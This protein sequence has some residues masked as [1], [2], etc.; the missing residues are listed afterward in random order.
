MGREEKLP[1][2]F[3]FLLKRNNSRILQS[4]A[5]ASSTH[6]IGPFAKIKKQTNSR[7]ILKMVTRT[8]F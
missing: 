4:Q 6:S 8:D 7:I 3:S 2:V 1:F 5:A